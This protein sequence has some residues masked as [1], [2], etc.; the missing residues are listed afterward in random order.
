VPWTP[1]IVLGIDPGESAGAAIVAEGKHEAD[2]LEL[3]G[4]WPVGAKHHTL[5]AG[6]CADFAALAVERRAYPIVGAENWNPGG[7][8]GVNE[9]ASCGA[10]FGMWRQ[11]LH[12]EFDALSDSHVERWKPT[13]WKS[14]ILRCSTAKTESGEPVWIG[15][16][17][18]Y[19]SKLFPAW[20][21]RIA[22]MTADELAAICL[23]LYTLRM[24]Q[25]TP[26]LL[27]MYLQRLEE[28]G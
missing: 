24:R 20:A 26:R 5:R 17:R 18:A 11:C 1:R 13:K 4:S 22:A 7:R 21:E 8:F 28:M 27:A 16:A 14:A 25:H 9:A 3:L 15:V 2:G 23:A 10:S 12:Y 6:V 19:L